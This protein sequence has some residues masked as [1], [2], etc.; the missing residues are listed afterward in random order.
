MGKKLIYISLFLTHLSFSQ[1][2]KTFT[3]SEIGIG[4]RWFNKLSINPYND[5]IWFTSNYAF[6]SIN[7]ETGVVSSY[8]KEFGDTIILA[9]QVFGEFSF[10]PNACFI[11]QPGDGVYKIKNDTISH[12][13]FGFSSRYLCADKDTVYIPNENMNFESYKLF[14]NQISFYG[15]NLPEKIIS[16][17]NNIWGGTI[18]DNN[19]D[20]I[21][22]NTIITYFQ[23]TCLLLDAIFY[24]FKFS[25]LTDSVYV[26]GEKGLSIAFGNKFIDSI[27][28]FSSINKPD[29]TIL[30][31]EFD[32]N[33][34]IWAKFGTVVNSNNY[35]YEKI[36]YYNQSTRTWSNFYD[37]TNSPIDFNE[38]FT[39][40]VDSKNNLW[41]GQKM[42]LFVLQ[43]GELPQWSSLTEK[44]QET[45]LNILPNPTLSIFKLTY[46]STTTKNDELVVTNQLGEIVISKNIKTTSG[47]NSIE[48][49]VEN[50]SN[51]IYFVTL[52]NNNSYSTTKLIKL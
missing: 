41:V 34:N 50:L 25:K 9:N 21:V 32:M 14:N 47:K 29:L 49:N 24:D 51:G 5:D 35:N 17:N 12:F 40:E 18:P 39:L 8:G 38:S 4:L 48:I 27:D 42:N 46:E 22:E 11:S 30:E 28:N 10:T 20:K 6:Y 19:F 37:S 43:N 1:Q 33:D 23:D 2:W 36:G 15:D 7:N 52:K 31:F 44:N 16:K 3:S 13:L 45:Y 26:G